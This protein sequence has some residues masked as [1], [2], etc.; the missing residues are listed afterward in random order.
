MTRGIQFGPEETDY[1][2]GLCSVS[3]VVIL[4]YPTAVKSHIVENFGSEYN[5]KVDSISDWNLAPILLGAA[6]KG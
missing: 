3:T 5:L 4:E 1:L 2:S 6:G